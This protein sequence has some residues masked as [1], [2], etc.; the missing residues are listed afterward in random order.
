M[1]AENP[2]AEFRK[3]CE[4]ALAHALKKILPEVKIEAFA[5]NKPPN[6]EFGQLASSLCFELAKKLNQ[7]PAELATYLAGAIDKQKFKLIE[8]VSAVGGYVNFHV[9]FAK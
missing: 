3:E 5:F 6:P 1:I 7:K 9:D 8:K 2:F 4:A